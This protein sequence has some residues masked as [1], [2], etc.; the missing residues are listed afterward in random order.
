M[1]S[2]VNARGQITLDRAVCEALGVEPGIIAVQMLIDGHLEIYFAPV[3]HERSLFGVLAPQ[4]SGPVPDW[5][6]LEERAAASIA[7]DALAAWSAC[8]NEGV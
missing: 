2:R 6:T 5:D 1:A 3:P 8:A 4:D 7:A